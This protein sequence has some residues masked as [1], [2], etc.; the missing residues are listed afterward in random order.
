MRDNQMRYEYTRIG[1]YPVIYITDDG[2]LLC[3]KCA[4][5]YDE[6]HA[7]HEGDPIHCDEC[8]EAVE[9]AYGNPE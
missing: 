1:G 4:G 6:G 2:S 8:N 3:G 7:H 9:S 5:E